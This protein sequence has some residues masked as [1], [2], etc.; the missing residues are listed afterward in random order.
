[1]ITRTVKQ[2]A[3]GVSRSSGGP[4]VLLQVDDDGPETQSR[5]VMTVEQTKKVIEDLQKQLNEIEK[6]EEQANW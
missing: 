5:A 1:M 2:G 4:F 3:V 6:T